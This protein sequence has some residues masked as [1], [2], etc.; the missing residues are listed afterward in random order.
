MS[1]HTLSELAEICGASL[2]GDG[3]TVVVGAAALREAGPD[4]VS[5]LSHARYRLDAE[6]TRAA[7]VVCPRDLKL[8]RSDLTLLRCDDANRSFTAIIQRFAED[9][10]RPDAGVHPTAVVHPTA[11]LGA[12]VT[13]G[14]YCV[15][16][17]GA[18]LG[19][20]VTCFSHVVVG[21]GS[22]IGNDCLLYASVVLYDGVTLG[23]RCIL[24]SGTILGADGFGFEPTA[25]GWIKVPQVGTVVVEDDVEM[26]A[27]CTVDRGRFGATRIGRGTKFDDQVHVAHNTN[28]GEHVMMAAQVGIAGSVRIGDRALIGGQVGVSGHL[29]IGAGAQLAAGSGIIGNI[30]AGEEWFG[31]PARP[32]RETLKRLGQTSRIPK[33]LTRLAALEG[34]LA[35]LEAGPSSGGEAGGPS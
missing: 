26:G 2:E 34:R 33:M 4:Q 32:R 7:A 8:E 19:D 27:T 30:P 13:L 15:V 31:Y 6:A 11:R 25:E 35:E 29:E 10:P 28:V 24:H 23:A 1:G 9:R 12:G 14:A 22:S 16:E 20:G 17:A 18:V 5:F 21:A 3:G